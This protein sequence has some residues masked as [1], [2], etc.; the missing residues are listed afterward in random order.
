[1]DA[2]VYENINSLMLLLSDAVNFCKCFIFVSKLR[3]SL[4]VLRQLQ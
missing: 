4:A 1:M 3:F 2:P